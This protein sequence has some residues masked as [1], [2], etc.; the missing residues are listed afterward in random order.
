MGTRSSENSVNAKFTH[1]GH[2][3]G[4]ECLLYEGP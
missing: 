4:P 2:S 1:K 3:P